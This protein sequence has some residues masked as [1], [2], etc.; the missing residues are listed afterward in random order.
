MSKFY[1]NVGYATSVETTPGVWTPEI[2]DKKYYGD[3]VKNASRFGPDTQINE[4]VSVSNEISIVADPYAYK[5]FNKIRYAEW[6]GIKWKV[7]NVSVDPP[8]LNLSLGGEYSEE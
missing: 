8:R 1:G 2:E 7:T 6:N 5:N 3:V 4:D